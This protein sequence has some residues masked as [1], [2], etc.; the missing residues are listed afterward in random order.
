MP[1]TE[2]VENF[3]RAELA[4]VDASHDWLHILRVRAN[5]LKLLETEQDAGRALEADRVVIELAAILHDVGDHKYSGSYEAGPETVR[6]FLASFLENGELTAQQVDKVVYIVANVSFSKEAAKGLNQDMPVEIPLELR[7]VQDA[8]RLDAIGA[9]GIA[10][11]MAFTGAR[12]R[13]FYSPGQ[14]PAKDTSAYG[15]F[16]DKLFKLKSIMKT[17]AGRQEAENRHKFMAVFIR[18][19]EDEAGL[20]HRSPDVPLS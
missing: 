16:F 19:L 17:E 20:P 7:I 10:R 6:R 4:N 11:C 18:Q 14:E 8:D 13:P 1:V 15:H 5:A 9:I 12:N 2:A 3:V